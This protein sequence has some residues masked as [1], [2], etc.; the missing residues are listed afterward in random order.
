MSERTSFWTVEL[1]GV[2]YNI[3]VGSVAVSVNS[4]KVEVWVIVSFRG[5][6]RNPSCFAPAAMGPGWIARVRPLSEEFIRSDGD[7]PD[8]LAGGMKNRI[9]DRS[10]G[11]GDSNFADPLGPD[12]A[13]MRIIFLNHDDIER[14]DIRIRRNVVLR[15][16]VIHDTA[17]AFVIDRVF[18]ESQTNAPNHATQELAPSGLLIQYSP[19][20]KCAHHAGDMNLPQVGVH[21]N[22]GK[23][24]AE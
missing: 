13:H 23:L 5:A 10:G 7:I 4:S 16:V 11:T 17:Q 2:E 9:R 15:K 18:V 20:G 14:T 1:F 21:T 22:L 12:R 3:R 6:V 24:S 8:A 19:G